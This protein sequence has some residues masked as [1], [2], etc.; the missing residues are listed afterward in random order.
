MF[1]EPSDP[2]PTAGGGDKN[3][4]NVPEQKGI[5]TASSFGSRENGIEHTVRIMGP[6]RTFLRP[7]FRITH[8]HDNP[9]RRQRPTARS[10]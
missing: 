9:G 1:K 4:G 6:A 3:C 5:A 2:L 10:S 8:T 7:A